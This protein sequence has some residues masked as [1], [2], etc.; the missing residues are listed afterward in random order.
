MTSFIMR[1]ILKPSAFW[2]IWERGPPWF[3]LGGGGGGING[4]DPA[5]YSPKRMLPLAPILVPLS[6]IT[7]KF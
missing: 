5:L 4:L 3:F 2:K 7:L 6:V 1:D